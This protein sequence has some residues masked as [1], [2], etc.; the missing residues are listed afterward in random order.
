M[1]CVWVTL[2]VLWILSLHLQSLAELA[3]RWV[4][5]VVNN[6][7]ESSGFVFH[8][9]FQFAISALYVSLVSYNISKTCLSLIKSLCISL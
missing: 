7:S 9:L 1:A 5:L 4:H 6:N 3:S 8:P 2:H